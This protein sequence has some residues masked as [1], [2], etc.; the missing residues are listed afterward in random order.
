MK[1]DG[2]SATTQQPKNRRMLLRKTI[3][4]AQQD[5][6]QR[7]THHPTLRERYHL[8]AGPLHTQTRSIGTPDQGGATRTR[9]RALLADGGVDWEA[10]KP[11]PNLFE[12]L[13]ADF[14]RTLL[15]RTALVATPKLHHTHHRSQDL[16]SEP[17]ASKPPTCREREKVQRGIKKGKERRCLRRQKTVRGYVLSRVFGERIT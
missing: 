14:Q 2:A 1:S 16:S 5:R 6:P 15:T 9:P 12:T 10:G 17:Q 11:W 8:R 4:K 3:P 13:N 7:D